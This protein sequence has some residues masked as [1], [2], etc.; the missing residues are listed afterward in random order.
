MIPAPP[1]VHDGPVKRQEIEGIVRGLQSGDAFE[2]LE[3]EGRL[4]AL[5]R[6]DFGFRWDGPEEE[7]AEALA[8]LRDWVRE[9]ERE[10][11]EARR[12]AAGAAALELA[13]LQGLSPEEAQAKLQA[14]L[15]KPHGLAAL[16]LGI[17]PCKDCGE[18]PATS[19]LVDLE[20][21][22]APTV[23]ALCETC[24]VRRPGLP[25]LGLT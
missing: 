18:H 25:G 6:R 23:V 22:R 8:R 4:R 13:K 11:R 2:R 12:T 5:A 19:E 14:L 15:S 20:R 16:G 1:G 7:R 9:R 17:V 10:R 21:G 24:L 3:A